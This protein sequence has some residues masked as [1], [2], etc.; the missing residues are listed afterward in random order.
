[1]RSTQS[2]F[3]DMA[4]LIAR[5]L[6]RWTAFL[7][8]PREFGTGRRIYP[9]EMYAIEAIGRTP[10]INVTHLADSLGVSKG[11]VSQT[12]G[13]LV[14]KGLVRKVGGT[15]SA[16]EV[17]LLLTQRGRVAFRNDEKFYRL[18]HRLFLARYG[19]GAPGRIRRFGETFSEFSAF[20]EVF[21][22]RCPADFPAPKQR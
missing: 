11:A 8:L 3:H 9:A 18:A 14:R 4:I 19:R 22:S 21:V 5:L 16:R 7:N 15:R 2:A 12:V 17:R 10:G 13:K 1:M 20:F 6:G